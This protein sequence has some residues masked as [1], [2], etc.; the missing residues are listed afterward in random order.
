MY[1]NSDYMHCSQERCSQ[2]N[3]C[4]RYWL[5][6]ES[7]RRKIQYV[8]FFMPDENEDLTN[9]IYFENKKEHE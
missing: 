1:Y 9:C 2:K 8:P 7:A 4:W 3:N 6:Q 5:G